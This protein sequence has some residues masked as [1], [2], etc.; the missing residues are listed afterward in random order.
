MIHALVINDAIQSVGPL[1]R[2]ARRLSDGAWVTPPAGEWTPEQAADAGY[3]PVT[4]TP[5]PD[6]TITTTHVESVVLVGG[7]PTQ[8]WTPRPWTADEVAAREAQASAEAKAV[9]DRA[10]LDATAALMQDAHEDGAAWVQPTGAHDAYALGAT[11]THGGKTWESLTPANVWAPGVSGWREVTTGGGIP[12]WV[13]P[14]GAH[15]A[16][17]LGAQVTHNGKTWTS[18]VAANVW[19]PGVYGWV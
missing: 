13:Q 1:P 6:D 12:A 3:F 17:P 5:R 7:V 19:E 18:T 14:T 2:A 9:E 11:A 8:T 16:Y 4:E 10:I 15:D